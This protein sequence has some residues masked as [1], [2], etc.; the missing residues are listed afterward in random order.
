MWYTITDT[1][2]YCRIDFV[3]S[4]NRF[5]PPEV[6][7]MHRLEMAGIAGRS[8]HLTGP[9]PVWMYAHAA[10]MA[11]ASGA[12]SVLSL[13]AAP[14]GI[15]NDT[16]GSYVTVSRAGDEGAAIVAI[17]LRPD[18]PLSELAIGRLLKP[19]CDQIR[20]HP[21]R[22]VCLTG[23][24]PVGVYAELAAVSVKSGVS[25]ISCFSP[26]SGLI[27]V[28]SN[29]ESAVRFVGRELPIPDWLES[30]VV[31]PNPGLLIG[32]I[33]D[34]NVGKSVFSSILDHYRQ[35]IR[36]SGWRF[37]CDGQ[38]PTPPW[39]LRQEASGD[40]QLARDR[41]NQN[42][43]RWS[44]EMEIGL[45]EQLRRQRMCFDVVVADLPGGNHQANPPE[46]IPLGRERLFHPIDSFV[47]VDRADRPSEEQ[48]REAMKRHGLEGRIVAVLR[49]SSPEGA[50]T[51]C[52]GCEAGAWRG[53]VTGLNRSQT[54]L[55]FDKSGVGAME[56]L[57]KAVT[58]SSHQP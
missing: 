1:G 46:R 6:L 49:S 29:E 20:S 48:W 8:I 30:H 10:A 41:R 32:V 37:D 47:L 22:W 36:L 39:Y 17:H 45:S 33:G 19:V 55:V 7:R 44:N 23:L 50:L 40:P 27:H 52:G 2:G 15:T 31:R 3:A 35:Q 28:Y 4:E 26:R 13:S 43:R 38:S 5:W 34:P 12:A 58:G 56:D 57:W 11:T 42:K 16:E 21:P 24:G 53:E 54:T 14:P 9:G 25:Q 51:L 18:F